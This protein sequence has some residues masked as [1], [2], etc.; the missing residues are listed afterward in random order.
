MLDTT[1]DT[2]AII[3]I[4]QKEYNV[5]LSKSPFNNSYAC[6]IVTKVSPSAQISVKV[7]FNNASQVYTLDNLTDT[8]NIDY[9]KAIE[10]FYKENQLENEQ[11]ELY[12]KVISS[13]IYSDLHFWYVRALKPDGQDY[14]CVIDPITGNVLARK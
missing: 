13:P 7:N 5:E 2:T 9:K 1:L 3:T 4:D 11:F 14:V 6:D 8:F 10:I 12:C